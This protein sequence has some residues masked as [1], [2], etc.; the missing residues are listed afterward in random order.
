MT[1]NVRKLARWLLILTGSGCLLLGLTFG[2]FGVVV[3]RV[4]EYRVQLQNWINER[5]GIRVEFKRLSARLRLYGPELVFDQAVVRTPDGTHVLATAKR[6]S[7]AFD[8]WSSI[9]HARLTAGRFSL[10][11]PELGLIRTK[12]GRIQLLGMSALP[13]RDKPFALEQLPMGRFYVRD[14][15]VTFRD[16][17]TGR[18]PWS[19]SGVSFDVTRD[20]QVLQ[21]RGNASLPRALG[22]ELRFSATV[23]GPLQ[24]A[25]ALVSTFSVDGRELD[26]A[27]WAD[28]F[29]DAWPAPEMGHGSVELRGTL[30]GPAL[31]Q[32]AADVDL[33]RVA[34]APP[35]WATALPVADPLITDAGDSAPQATEPTPRDPAETDP[36]AAGHVAPV[37]MLS[38]PRLAFGMRAEKVGE[39]WHATVSNLNMARPTAAWLAASIEG[40]WLHTDNGR[41]QASGKTD[42]IVLD[43]L[44]PLLG[45]LPESDAVARLRALNAT[46]TLSEV[47][48]EFQRESAESAPQ[49]SLQ[50]RVD[51]LSFAPVQRT[52]GAAGLSG[53]VRL[54]QDAGEWKVASDDVRFELPRMFREPLAAQ[55]VAATVRWN[56]SNGAWTIESNDV[57]MM[58]PDG[59]ATARFSMTVPGDGSSPV[60]DL[61]AQGT[62]LQVSS[63]HKYIPAGRL[64]A[65]TMEWFDRAFLGGR[66]VSA[67]LTYRGSIRDFPFRKDEGL[68]LVRGHVEDALFDYQPGWLPASNVTADLEFR[69]EGLHI[70]A[71]GANV[72]GLHVID[73][74]ADIPDLKQTHLRIKA[75]ARGDLQEGLTLLNSSPLASALGEPFARLS[76]HGAIDAAI[77]LDLPIR[78]LDARKIEV[79]ARFADANVSMRD[80]DAPV[81]SLQGTLTVRNTLVAAADLH[82]QWLGG[83]VEV[84]IRPEGNTASTLSATGTA[85][86]AQL[87]PFLPSAVKV[88]GSTQWRLATEFHTDTGEAEHKSGVRIESDL[89]GLG[90]ALPEPVGK[91]ESEQRPFQVTLESDGDDAVLARSWLGDVRAI[92]R[93]ARSRGGGSWS[94]DRGGIRADGNAPALPNHRGLRIEGTVERFVLDD[95]LALR[96]DDSGGEAGDSGKTLSDYL[97]AANVRVGMFELAGY[98][99]HDVRGVLQATTAGWRVDVDGPGAAG[100]IL[101]PEQFR[102]SQ[103][104]R[105]TLER[106]TLE[107]PESS[108]TGDAP[109]T[110][111]PR[112]LPNLLVHVGE[113]SF[114]SRTLGTFDLQATRVPQGIRFENASIHGASAHAEG[115]GEWIVTPEGQQSSLKAAVTS[116]DVAATLRA[117][118]YNDVLEAKH[119]EV[120]GDLK[121]SGGFDSDML[122]RAAGSISVKAETGQILA[123]QPGAGRVLGLFSV[124]ALPRRLALDFKDL[125]DKGLAFDKVQGDFEVRDGN[126][127][128]SNLL[129]RGPAAEIGIAGRTGLATHDYDQTAVVTGNLGASLPVAGALAGGPVV[130][131]AVL[132]FSQI[133][134][135][136]L[137][138]VTRGYY[139][140]TG[141]WENPTVERVDAA[142]IKVSEQQGTTTGK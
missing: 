32:V 28:V 127:F 117:L 1:V 65:R 92:V 39:T 82:G 115:Q 69:N 120:H 43:A 93:V 10:D 12:E 89:R 24:D 27:G 15:V 79:T 122:D 51:D 110:R 75:A 64:G 95:W 131:A 55:E 18:G 38:Y 62:D 70:H 114:G 83:P 57:R 134:K 107:K 14:A 25:A 130:G 33:E 99:W 141:P 124:A 128:T 140:I 46:G 8:L 34:A 48:F 26:L 52:P 119:G 58:N 137:K 36:G 11:S 30:K 41:M 103:V 132:L 61:S 133:F 2:A 9:R 74:T 67:D 102:G 77:D 20:P 116:D 90:I 7:V 104:L 112:N 98:Q 109:D 105:A 101:I 37:A 16:A 125:T 86:A 59:R 63:T 108:G 50:A 72:G 56:K 100:Q 53:A 118:G 45:Y 54:T 106:L 113:L 3:S 111:D 91:G 19:L 97:Q 123:V 68:F 6:G 31:V 129:L 76:G 35:P 126:A 4:P 85:A 47:S 96:G 21:L 22:R 66:V 94:L 81:R 142:A 136:P 78:N 60:L 121:W 87:K 138:G 139:R 135:E 84:V 49:Y 5:G 17:I 40:E 23:E 71:T 13:D 73:A 29:P 44:W 42:R 88:S 80:V